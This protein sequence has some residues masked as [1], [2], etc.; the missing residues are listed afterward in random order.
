MLVV[1][2]MAHKSV[3]T[4][5]TPKETKW[6]TYVA[7]FIGCT[8]LL[9]VLIGGLTVGF[10]SWL[11][12]R[13]SVS[14]EMLQDLG[15]EGVQLFRKHDRNGDGVLSL[16]EFEPLAHRLLQSEVKCMVLMY[17]IFDKYV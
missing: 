8:I 5:L 1:T 11:E 3:Q 9:G 2:R 13:F 17:N 10:H 4:D 16:E 6:H 14:P 15:V 12:P 7:I